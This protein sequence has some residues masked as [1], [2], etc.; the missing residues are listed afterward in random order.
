MLYC[1]EKFGIL[2]YLAAA[3]AA[4]GVDHPLGL[5]DRLVPSH[6]APPL[7]AFT[8]VHL[9]EVFLYLFQY[10]PEY[11]KIQHSYYTLKSDFCIVLNFS[12]EPFPFFTE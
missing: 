11:A 6:K 1:G 5:K 4:H 10:I 7:R 2:Y 8:P 12:S 3:V 9:S